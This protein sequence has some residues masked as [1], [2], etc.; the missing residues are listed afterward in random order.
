SN[1][2]R[3]KEIASSLKSAPRNDTKEMG[4]VEHQFQILK[5]LGIEYK[6]DFF[7]ELW[8]SP[9]DEEYVQTLLDGE[10]LGN[11]THIV[12][13]N[14]AASAKWE[15]KNWPLEHIARLCNIL[16]AKNIRVILT[17]TPKDKETARKLLSMVKSKPADLIGKTDVPQ[18]AALIKRCQVF[19]TPDSA[20]M[21]VAAAVGTPFI[22]F[23]GPTEANRHLPPAKRF[24][25][26]NKKLPCS[27]CYSSNCRIHTHA[28]MNEISP[29]EVA[30]NIF[31]LMKE[32]I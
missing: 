9:K 5:M 12:G 21:H 31:N 1:L 10:W 18:L 11:A 29:E 14:L 26:L 16:S 6:P 32:K 19:V 22:A 15:T 30:K 2:F 8:P 23:F 27:P 7:L 25:V 4:P 13:I 24:V 3:S 17:G 20:P 28:C